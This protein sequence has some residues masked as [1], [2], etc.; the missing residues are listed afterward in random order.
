MKI[1]IDIS[2]VLYGTGVSVYTRELVQNLL[3]IDK[4]NEY[5]LFGGSLRRKPELEAFVSNLK[6]NFKQ[7]LVFFPPTLADLL[8]NRLHFP[9]VEV[10]TGKIAVFHSSD[11][12][13]PP[14]KAFTVTTV[15]DLSPIRFKKF[16]HPKIVS[17]H[18][19]RLEIVKREVDRVIC[20]SMAI[21][22]DL[23]SLGVKSGKIRVIAEAASPIYK[24][25]KKN[26]IERLKKKYKIGG[27][28][29]LSVGINPRKN[30]DKIIKAFD[31]ARAGKDLKLVL[32]GLPTFMSVDE[33]RDVRL[34]GHVPAEDMPA[35]Y[36]G[37]EALV[38]TSLYEGF[39]LPILEAMACGTPVVTSNISSFPEAAGTAAVLV[40]PYDV[41]SIVEGIK[42]AMR[43]RE[44]LIK[45][46]FERVKKFSWKKTAEETLEVYKESQ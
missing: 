21:K 31:L 6:G 12:A 18:K 27:K 24:P 5:V 29:L 13:Q 35:F 20:P 42:S 10:F 26:E 44:T 39:G 32:V 8:W 33:R 40:D 1:G 19:R 38:Y 17:V 37:A 22:E 25:A 11:W 46:G 2:S 9:P 3:A 43:R 16:T 4:E 23:E 36:S 34:V 41:D 15:H 14:T 28:Y 45:K 7:N 30:T